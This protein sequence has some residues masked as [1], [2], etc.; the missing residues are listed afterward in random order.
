MPQPRF[1]FDRGEGLLDYEK[2]R[3][4]RLD[5]F[6]LE[7]SCLGRSEGYRP[8]TGRT[9]FPY[10]AFMKELSRSAAKG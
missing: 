8:Q 3:R 7:G 9:V 2:D 1:G 5:G 6:A 10:P 4:E